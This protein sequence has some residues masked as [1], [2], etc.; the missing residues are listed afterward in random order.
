MKLHWTGEAQDDL[1]NI[2]EYIAQDSPAAAARV[3]ATIFNFTEEQLSLPRIGR[4]GR[5]AGTFELVIPKLPYTVPYRIV[6]DE[7]H[8]LRVYHQSRLWPDML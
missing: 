8:I 1:A 7:I 6:D 3:V 4:Q 2:Q 5:I